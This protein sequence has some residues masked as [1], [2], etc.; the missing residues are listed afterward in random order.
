MVTISHPLAQ[1]NVPPASTP[2]AMYT[3]RLV[4]DETTLAEE[5]TLVCGVATELTL[6]AVCWV[7]QSRLS[8]WNDRAPLR[9]F[10]ASRSII[11]H[12]GSCSGGG[13]CRANQASNAIRVGN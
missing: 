6:V 1:Y 13:L 2:R 4:L 10:M 3:L 7:K 5:E 12:P 9:S 11:V 8:R